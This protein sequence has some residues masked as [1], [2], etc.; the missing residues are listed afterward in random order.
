MLILDKKELV[1]FSAPHRVWQ[2]IPGIERT[3]HGRAFVTFYSGG[4]TETYGNY[5]LL[6][7]SD[8]EENR[9]ELVAAVEKEGRFRCFDPVL[10]IDPIGRLW[11]VWNVMPGEE[12][13]AVICN[14]PDADELV[15]SE[16]FYIGR[17]IMMNKPTVLSSGEWL[18]PIAQW[19]KEFGEKLRASGMRDTDIPRAYVYKTSDNGATFIQLGG[20]DVPD[21]RFDEHMVLELKNGVLANYVRT[22]Y[23]IGVSYS[24]DRGLT[25]S[26]GDDSGLGGPC[27][28]F[29]IRRLRSGR[30]LLINHVNYTGRNNL[31][32]LLSED[33]GKSY[34]YSIMLDE[35]AAVSYPDVTESKDGYLYIIYDRER[36]CS[37]KSLDEAYSSAREILLAKITEQDII[38]GSIKD[39]A[40]YLKRI[41]SKLGKLADTDENPYKDKELTD[42]EFAEKLLSEGECDV[43]KVFS[44][45]PFN[46]TSVFDMDYKKAEALISDYEKADCCD[47]ELLTRI[48]AIFR[49]APKQSANNTPIIDAIKKYI[50]EHLCE[51][52][53][54]GDLADSLKISIYYMCHMF[55]AATGITITEYCNSLRITKAKQLL[56]N[57]DE[58]ILDIA[59]KCGF[60]TAAYFTENFTRTERIA[61]TEYRKIHKR[62]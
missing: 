27:S 61:P 30:I 57:T 16:E 49:S 47:V 6:Y 13:Y 8:N 7:K 23:G 39:S 34:P 51:D 52:F 45:F 50:E 11:L 28:R 46:C 1:R 42:R 54:I 26:R 56:I 38:N 12:V 9:W 17:G 32:A 21:R 24:Y 2:G 37:K 25:W 33:D 5:V 14:D 60:C 55:K 10:W 29:H 15:W 48:I 20:A 40:S 31:C 35:R 58:S 19:K 18:F 22:H 36:G 59:Q 3:E 53:R 41:V 44:L 62:I 4:I 43:E